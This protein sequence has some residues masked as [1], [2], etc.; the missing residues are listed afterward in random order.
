MSN[1]RRATTISGVLLVM[2]L[3]ATPAFSQADFTGVWG[4]RY[5]ED[6]PER[7]PGPPLADYIGLPIS[8]AGRKFALSW[9]PERLGLPEHQ[10]Q[11]HTV[12]YIYRGP[13]QMRSWEERD[14][15]SQQLVAIKQYINTYEQER[16]IW[17]DGR[18]HPSPNAPHTWMGFSTGEWEGSMLT[19]TTTHIKQGWHRRNGFPSSDRITLREHFMRHGDQL[20]HVTVVQDPDYLDEPLIKTQNF[21]LTTTGAGNW[22]WPCEYVVESA[23]RKQGDVPQFLPGENPFIDE[24]ATRHGLPVDATLGGAKTMYPEYQKTLSEWFAK[25]GK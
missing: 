24:F 11:V 16:T 10:C 20:V 19:V 4:A 12:A 8:D 9:N 6:Q 21:V 14:P 13:L 25:G 23:D 18:P 2:T 17:M 22:L 5:H 3:A 1:L 15:Q 7:I